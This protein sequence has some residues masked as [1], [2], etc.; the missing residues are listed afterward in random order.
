MYIDIVQVLILITYISIAIL[1]LGIALNDKYKTNAI[2][3]VLLPFC[4]ALFKLD[5]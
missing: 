3:I 4:Q 1:G 5:S 2:G